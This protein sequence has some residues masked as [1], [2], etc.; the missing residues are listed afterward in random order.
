MYLNILMGFVAFCLFISQVFAG[1]PAGQRP[2]GKFIE[3]ISK[4]TQL[5]EKETRER[6]VE[7]LRRTNRYSAADLE[8]IRVGGEKDH[9]SPTRENEMVRL[10]QESHSFH[11]ATGFERLRLVRVS[12]DVRATLVADA[13]KQ[14]FTELKAVFDISQFARLKF[15][16]AELMVQALSKRGSAAEQAKAAKSLHET[17]TELKTV[18]EDLDFMLRMFLLRYDIRHMTSPDKK[19]PIIF[20]LRDNSPK[21]VVTEIERFVE[22][23]VADQISSIQPYPWVVIDAANLPAKTV[24]IPEE[25]RVYLGFDFIRSVS[26]VGN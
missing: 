24:Y 25:R 23:A 15:Q 20:V 1:G 12:E 4:E 2:L 5:S 11:F 8:R 9:F 21:Q 6:A 17:K 14:A 26:S 3:R 18:S 16:A 7:A 10:L 22:S 19:E 13:K